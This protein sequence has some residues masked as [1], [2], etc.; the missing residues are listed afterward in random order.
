MKTWWVPRGRTHGIVEVC[1]RL[2]PFSFRLTRQSLAEPPV[3]HQL[4]LKLSLLALALTGASAPGFL[5][6]IQ[7]FS[8]LTCVSGLQF[9]LWSQ[10][11]DCPKISCWFHLVHPFCCCEDGSDNSQD[12]YIS[13]CNHNE[14]NDQFHIGVLC[15]IMT[16]YLL[17]N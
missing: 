2:G 17:M 9:F 7:W 8:E 13:D 6:P 11:S 4:Q 12:F 15:E 14:K 16:L 3:N 10:F 1:L 5:L